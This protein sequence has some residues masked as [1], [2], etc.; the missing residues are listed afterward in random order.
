MWPRRLKTSRP[1]GRNAQ[2]AESMENV[3]CLPAIWLWLK[4]PEYQN[5]TL[6]S[7]HMDQ[8][9]RL[10]TPSENFATRLGF[11]LV[12]AGAFG[13]RD[14]EARNGR[15]VLQGMGAGSSGRKP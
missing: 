10:E 6:V 4:K 8:N 9:L 2:H 11:W 1:R 14:E 13:A 12:A 7:G 3:F 15:V 5:G